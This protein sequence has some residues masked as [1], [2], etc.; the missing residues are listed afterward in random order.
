MADQHSE[1]ERGGSGVDQRPAQ[2]LLCGVAQRRVAAGHPGQGVG[3]R[4]EGGRALQ[5]HDLASRGA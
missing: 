4:S 3:Q 2:P 1:V 5:R